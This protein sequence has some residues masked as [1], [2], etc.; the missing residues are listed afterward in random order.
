[1]AD[2]F[3]PIKPDPASDFFVFDFTAQ[4]G[5]MGGTIASVQWMVTVDASSP[6]D[7]PDPTS[8]IL[9]TPTFSS[10]KTSALLGQMIDGVIYDIK[11]EATL[12]K[13]SLRDAVGYCRTRRRFCVRRSRPPM[14]T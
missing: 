5:P 2:A 1:M 12:T 11:A 7:D 8:R 13:F 10:N 14:S 3:G 6:V 9:A 4:I